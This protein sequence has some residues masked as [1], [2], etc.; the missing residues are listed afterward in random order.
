MLNEFGF[1]ADRPPMPAN[2]K[3]G[4]LPPPD[5][6]RLKGMGLALQHPKGPS[7]ECRSASDVELSHRQVLLN[8]LDGE[9]GPSDPDTPLE[10]A[11]AQLI[12]DAIGDNRNASLFVQTLG[13][14]KPESAEKLVRTG[15]ARETMQKLIRKNSNLIQLPSQADLPIKS[16]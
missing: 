10:F 13:L 6:K 14:W 9:L 12:H 4:E 1:I 3:D 5:R 2:T 8:I 7:E 15:R 16:L 11:K